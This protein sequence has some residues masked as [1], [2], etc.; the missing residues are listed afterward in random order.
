MYQKYFN[1][2]PLYR[3]EQDWKQCGADIS[4]TTFA[5]WMIANVQDF[6]R[7]TYAYLHKKLFAQSY[8][9]ADGTYIQNRAPYLATYLEDGRYSLTNNLR[10]NAI[11]PFVVGRK[12]WLFSDT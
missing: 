1:G 7:L 3:H 6:F 4:R 2:M 8:A 10:E 11:R 5:N 12:C 9:M